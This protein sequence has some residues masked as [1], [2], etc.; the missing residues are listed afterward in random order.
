MGHVDALPMRPLPCE[1][2]EGWGGG[3][4]DAR[5]SALAPLPTSPRVRGEGQN[6]ACGDSS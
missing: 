6:A 4:R 2:G 1:A 3:K 5:A